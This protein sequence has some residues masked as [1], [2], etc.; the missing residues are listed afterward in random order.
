MIAASKKRGDRLHL[1]LDSGKQY[2]S[3]PNCLSTY[4]SL[5]HMVRHN[6]KRS[7]DGKY[8][9]TRN[10]VTRRSL[11]N[12]DFKLHCFFGGK[13]CSLERDP[14]NPNHWKRATLCKT[15]DRGTGNLSYK[16]V[17]LETGEQR[18]DKWTEEV[19]IRV[20]GSL[21]DLHASDAKYHIACRDS[22]MSSRNISAAC[23]TAF[24]G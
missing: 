5:H 6:A 11:P 13:Y 2:L 20:S 23:S 24:W 19:Q 3:H 18:G 16:D 15:S 21:S 1:S 17:V 8:N 22:F 12:F 7:S 4:T 10:K 14:K 9:H